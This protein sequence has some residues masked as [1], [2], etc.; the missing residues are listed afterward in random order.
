M[1]VH[2]KPEGYN[3]VTPYLYIKGAA[4]AIE[5][6][7][8]VFGAKEKVRMPNPDGTI[9]HAEIGIGDSVIMLGDEQ[10]AMGA[11]SP[12]T[13]GGSPSSIMLYLP[14]VDAVVERAVTGGA[15]VTRP[16]EDKFYGDR[17]AGIKDP[18][19]F[20]WFIGTHI[21]DMTLEEMMEA[22]KTAE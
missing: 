12:E 6:Y 4:K 18:F 21:K 14:D 19:G 17:V 22:A 10:P 3:S 2:F 20:P 13:V 1:A 5:F 9:G 16:A 7:T 8:T 15:V 11:L